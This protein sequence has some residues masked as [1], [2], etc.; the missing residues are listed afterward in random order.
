M[1]IRDA[2]RLTG[3]VAEGPLL[4]LTEPLSLW[5]GV[6]P[7]SGRI[8][9]ASHPQAGR[10]ISGTI[11]MLTYGRGSSSASSVLAEMIRKG[12]APAAIILAHPDPI[13]VLGSVVAHELYGDTLPVLLVG[14][15]GWRA[16]E[17][18]SR[19]RIDIDGILH[20]S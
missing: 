13:I 20:L 3:G 10:V 18:A 12:T 7:V 6:D 9:E 15:D 1:V 5:G 19:G 16:A 11:L 14:S 4:T 2:R 8:I 17:G